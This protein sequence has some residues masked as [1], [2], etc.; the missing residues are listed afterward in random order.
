MDKAG[1]KLGSDSSV[2]PTFGNTL[3]SARYADLQ[4]EGTHKGVKFSV[5]H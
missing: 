2:V 4:T 3:S 5:E 1:L